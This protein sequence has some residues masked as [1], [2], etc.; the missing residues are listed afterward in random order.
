MQLKHYVCRQPAMESPHDSNRLRYFSSDLFFTWSFKVK[1]SSSEND[2]EFDDWN[3]RPDSISKFFPCG[4]VGKTVPLRYRSDALFWLI[5]IKYEVSLTFR[6][7]LL[8]LSQ[9]S[10]HT[11]SLLTVAWTLLMSLSG[12]KTGVSSAKWTKQI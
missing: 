10:T 2:K 4:T 9:L 7:S 3:F 8:D 11:S 12:G 6:E 5:G 1:S